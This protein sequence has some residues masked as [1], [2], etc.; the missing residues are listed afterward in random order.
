M[1]QDDI[2]RKIQA[3]LAKAESTTH[4][5]EAETFNAKAQELMLRHAIAEADLADA[6]QAKKG[7][8]EPEPFV[9]SGSDANLP[10]KRRL[11]TVACRMAGVK[12]VFYTGSRH[13]QTAVLIG[14]KSDRE[15]AAMLYAS[16]TLQVTSLGRLAYDRDRPPF[17]IKRYMTGFMVG[18][19][20]RVSER[21]EQMTT[22]VDKD[23]GGSLLPVLASKE[24]EVDEAFNRHFPNTKKLARNRVDAQAYGAGSA[25]GARA[26]IG[27]RKVGGNR[28]SLS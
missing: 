6:G 18:F 1:S 17:G 8:I 16:F 7:A 12:C 13:K 9:Y 5:A 11:L 19:G 27:G 3:M 14:Y 10:G 24:A 4:E 21:A 26:D 28:K 25:A 15:Y 20:D 22:T 2:I 23:T